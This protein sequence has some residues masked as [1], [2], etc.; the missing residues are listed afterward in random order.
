MIDLNRIPLRVK[1]G[2]FTE[3]GK[4]VNK[5]NEQRVDFANNTLYTLF[6]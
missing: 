3:D 2:I 6:L 5:V 1:V 4:T